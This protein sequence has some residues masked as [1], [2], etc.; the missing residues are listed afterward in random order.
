MLFSLPTNLQAISRPVGWTNEH[1]GRCYY[2]L[3]KESLSNERSAGRTGYAK[4]PSAEK[5]RLLGFKKDERVE[6]FLDTIDFK[7]LRGVFEDLHKRS[8]ADPKNMN[9]VGAERFFVEDI[10]HGGAQYNA[11]ENII[12]LSRNKEEGLSIERVTPHYE[13]V[14]DTGY[15]AAPDIDPSVLKR[16]HAI[17]LIIHEETHA[18]GL[19]RLEQINS[20]LTSF[21]NQTSRQF[22][23]YKVYEQ[24]TRNLLWY[25]AELLGE[26]LNEGITQ[27]IAQQTLLEYVRRSG[28]DNHG[29]T[30]QEVQKYI[31]CSNNDLFWHG[32]SRKPEVQ[33]VRIF[34]EYLAEAAET[35]PD[36]IW[37]GIER[38]Y[39]RGGDLFDQSI[40][41]A[42]EEVGLERVL[43][44][45][46]SSDYELTQISLDTK[47]DRGD[48]ARRNAILAANRELFEGLRPDS[49]QY[50]R[51]L[52]ND[53]S[54][55]KVR[56]GTSVKTDNRD[57][58]HY[59]EVFKGDSA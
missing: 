34:I 42:F 45:F 15:F 17:E 25:R 56:A 14:R 39:I 20:F 47:Q 13:P 28:S 54:A 33:F 58:Q 41:D 29:V 22:S 55:T 10:E 59:H 1:T 3:V 5:L 2:G 8:G 26:I 6:K 52:W 43:D 37:E 30:V 16:I 31:S 19:Q 32:F 11:R 57:W 18:M 38:G 53:N 36:K 50:L 24:E 21:I 12:M 46:E 49:Q 51:E 7:T 48:I 35:S 44:V 23:G 4:E 40:K 27:M 9:L